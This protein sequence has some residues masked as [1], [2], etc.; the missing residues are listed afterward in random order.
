MGE[1]WSENRQLTPRGTPAGKALSIDWRRRAC[2]GSRSLEDLP[3]LGIAHAL[4]V[5]R[6]ASLKCD[7]VHAKRHCLDLFAGVVPNYT[8]MVYQRQVAITIV[9]TTSLDGN[10]CREVVAAV[11]RRR[12]RN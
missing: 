6:L 4:D 1:G 2:R 7:F 3:C 10:R 9:F 11:F 12:I 5:A 8:A